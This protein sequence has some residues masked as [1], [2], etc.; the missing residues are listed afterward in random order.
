MRRRDVTAT[1]VMDAAAALPS[2]RVL[3]DVAVLRRLP[4]EAET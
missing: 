2:E 3:F 4:H 1:L